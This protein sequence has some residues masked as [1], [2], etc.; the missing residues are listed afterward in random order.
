M[1]LFYCINGFFSS[2]DSIWFQFHYDL[3]LFLIHQINY[4][5]K[6]YFNF[7]MI[8]FYLY[9]HFQIQ[10][11]NVYFNFIMILFYYVSCKVTCTFSS[12]FQFHYDLILLIN[13]PSFI[14]SNKLISISLWSYSIYIIIF[15]YN[16]VMSISISLWSYSIYNIS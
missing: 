2:S 1:I 5:V 6:L 14:Y 13:S 11:C 7:I 10:H 9:H 12:E 4:C 3:I 15:K 8:L 16:H